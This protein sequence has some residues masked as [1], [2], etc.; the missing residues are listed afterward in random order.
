MKLA[1]YF[2]LGALTVAAL[3]LTG[4]KRGPIVLRD[5]EV[6]RNEIAF[7]QMALEQDTELLAHHLADGSCSCDE[8]EWSSIECEDT[9]LNILV[10]RA[11]LPWHV[12][13]MHYLGKLSEERPPEEPPEVP[14][15]STLCPEG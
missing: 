1:S 9:A 10:I 15:S 2:V 3:G 8:G 14:E 11:R 6:Y 13:M 12:A 5:P 7:M 4:C